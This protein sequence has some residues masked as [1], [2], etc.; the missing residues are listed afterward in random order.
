MH[1]KVVVVGGAG[2]L[3]S[4]L[5]QKLSAIEPSPFVLSVDYTANPKAT[6][7]LILSSPSESL[8][9]LIDR[10]GVEAISTFTAV[11]CV[12]GGWQGGGGDAEGS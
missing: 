6:D 4:A 1:Q 5:I 3:G 12:A 7:S 8:P 11:Y 2:A 10:L 9:Q